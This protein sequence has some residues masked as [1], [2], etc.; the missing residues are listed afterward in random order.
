MTLGEVVEDREIR[1]TW[2]TTDYT[3]LPKAC[4]APSFGFSEIAP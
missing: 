4:Q 3:S 2:S 1:P